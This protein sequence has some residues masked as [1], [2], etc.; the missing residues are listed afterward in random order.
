MGDMF[1]KYPVQIYEISFNED[2]YSIGVYADNF[3]EYFDDI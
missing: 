2:D 1:Y 3:L